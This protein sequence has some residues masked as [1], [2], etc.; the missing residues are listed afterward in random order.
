MNFSATRHL[1]ASTL[2][3]VLVGSST[4]CFAQSRE[5]NSDEKSADKTEANK[6][7]PS[8]RVIVP[9]DGGDCNSQRIAY[10]REMRDFRNR[11]RNSQVSDAEARSMDQ[12]AVKKDAW[13]EK[14]CPL[15]PNS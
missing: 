14:N 2:L 6:P 11:A 15:P 4:L 1:I 3:A 9:S 12:Y 10:Q 8:G 5:S 7:A 13:F